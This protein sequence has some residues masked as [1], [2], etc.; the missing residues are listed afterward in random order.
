[1]MPYN[2]SYYPEQLEKYGLLKRQDL[3]AYQL[4]MRTAKPDHILKLAEHTQRKQE[5]RVRHLSLTRYR[6][7]MTSIMEILNDAYAE[8][9]GFTPLAPGELNYFMAKLK[10]VLVPEL[11]NFVEVDGEPAAFS[12][13]LPNYNE[14]LKRFSRPLGMTDMLKFYWYSKQIKTLR[15]ALLAVRK[16]HQRK[17]LETLLYQESFRQARELGYTS[18]EI[19]W[20]SEDDSAL[21]QAVQSIGGQRTKTYRVYEIQL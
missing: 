7:D 15:F 13:I 19:S 6:R 14:V 18:A 2:P 1:M 10:P 16:K 5:A 11:V 20:V 9:F 12:L 8:G 3:Y 17:G 4:D 21:N